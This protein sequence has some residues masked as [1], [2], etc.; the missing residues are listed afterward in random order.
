MIPIAEP[1]LGVEE[2]NNVV[3]AVKSGWISSKGKFVTEF[4]EVF[5]RYCGV[6][7]GIATSNG[8]TALHL[9]LVVLGIG[10]G[11]EV[12]VPT[13]TFIAT[14]NAVTFTGA[15]PVFVD[16]HPKYWCMD[17]AKIE[18]MITPRTKAII[19][20][21]L[22][23]H[24][25]DM[26][27]INAI[28]RAHKLSV[29]EDAAEAH[30]AEY[31][32]KKIGS[33]SDIACFSFYGNKIITTGE[34]GM[35]LTDNEELAVKL[36]ILRDHG[37]HP[38]RRYWHDVIGFNYRMTNLQAAIG[39]AQIKKID[40]LI[41]R[42]R[43]LAKWYAKAL[44]DLRR[45]A[46]LTLP[47]EMPWAKNVYW[48]YTILLS[49]KLGLTRDEIAVKLEERGTETRPMFYPLHVMPPYQNNSSFSIAEDLSQ[50]GLSLP[51]GFNIGKAEVAEICGHISS[52]FMSRI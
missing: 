5:A 31:K 6:K 48:M 47:S 34:G 41:E 37:Q 26:D 32:G 33:F 25:C 11:D 23:G 35:C 39:V 18:Q 40:A 9:A 43:Q 13:L 16:S 15:K 50:K 49:E 29:I 24:P 2:L 51:C 17:P 1:L 45:D 38:A 10:R 52:L 12:I 14:A 42:K 3:E 28:A 44:E 19:P 4:E 30:G 22:Y 27:L 7:Y 21:H 20:V 8:T 36:Q 46:D